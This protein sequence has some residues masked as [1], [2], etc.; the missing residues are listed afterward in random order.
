MADIHLSSR[1]QWLAKSKARVIEHTRRPSKAV[2]EMVN[3]CSKNV[4]GLLKKF[5]GDEQDVHTV[6]ISGDLVDHNRNICGEVKKNWRNDE[7]W[8]LVKLKDK[9]GRGAG[10]VKTWNWTLEN[11]PENVDFLS[12][13]S[14]FVKFYEGQLGVPPKPIFAVAGNHDDYEYPFGIYPLLVSSQK[15]RTN[16]G[17]PADHNL[18]IY[19][20]C[21][22]F[23]ETYHAL[24]KWTNNSA[25]KFAWFYE[26]FTPFS[27]FALEL[28]KHYLVGLAW[29][30][31]E[32][33]KEIFSP[34][35]EQGRGF[36][37]RA[38]KAV[39][40]SQK[41]LLEEVLTRD[42]GPVILASHFTFASYREEISE[43]G[44]DRV[45]DGNARGTADE[46]PSIRLDGK[47]T[48][49]DMGTF[50]KERKWL[51]GLVDGEAQGQGEISSVLTGHSHRRG[52]YFLEADGGTVKP[53]YYVF[54]PDGLPVPPAHQAQTAIIVSDSG[55]SIP[56]RNM[57]G[58]FGGWGSDKPSGTSVLFDDQGRVVEVRAV[59]VDIAGNDG[60]K[61]RLAVSLDYEDVIG[62]DRV[63]LSFESDPVPGGTAP[64]D[65]E[66]HL[67]MGQRRRDYH[68]LP[69]EIAFYAF[70]RSNGTWY[71]MTM[72]RKSKSPR[73]TNTTWTIRSIFP[74]R[75]QD[76]AKKLK[77]FY[78]SKD[79]DRVFMS[80]K[81]EPL[82]GSPLRDFY[83]FASPWTFEAKFK[84][85]R[86]TSRLKAWR[87][88]K[89]KYVIKRDK[90]WCQ[91]PDFKRRKQYYDRLGVL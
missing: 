67:K 73:G 12:L 51:Y 62:E 70:R 4:A 47:Y 85:E 52:L 26:V 55:G 64:K 83:D 31:D 60:G 72:K 87:E 18:T 38:N 34:S 77:V 69:S 42:G 40:G 58:E 22:A 16:T 71:R 19:E 28:P 74:R 88:P 37:P 32:R 27:D 3:V 14:L 41:A 89:F 61:P 80:I 54:G 1:Q 5:A 78:A 56:R 45:R 90:V 50:E 66:F 21:L 13:Y 39:S 29:G 2:G 7:I 79:R 46:P 17:I 75:E 33:L 10:G 59:Q 91:F 25:D 8:D 76:D 44:A 49:A 68:I 86:V 65:I 20:A 30:D 23:G 36:L 6:V 57:F 11:Y 9:G 43:E 84:K 82:P 63:I 53:T 24:V 81:F 35:G 48:L 15:G